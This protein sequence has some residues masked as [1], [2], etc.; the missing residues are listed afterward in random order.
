MSRDPPSEYPRAK[1]L[2]DDNTA[3]LP[4]NIHVAP[5]GGAATHPRRRHRAPARDRTA[6]VGVGRLPSNDRAPDPGDAGAAPTDLYV[7]PGLMR[8]A[9]AI[10]HRNAVSTRFRS[11]SAAFPTTNVSFKSPWYLRRRPASSAAVRAL[12]FL[13]SEALAP[14]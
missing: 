4:R 12:I 8:S 2:A 5:R 9:P 13:A 3:T 11:S 1:V 7:V 14:S 6:A 10:K